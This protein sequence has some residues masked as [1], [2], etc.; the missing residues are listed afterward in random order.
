MEDV[1]AQFQVWGQYFNQ[2][3]TNLKK[4]P[5]QSDQSWKKFCRWFKSNVHLMCFARLEYLWVNL[6]PR[7]ASLL[8]DQNKRRNYAS[9]E[10]TIGVILSTLLAM[11]IVFVGPAQAS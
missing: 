8:F 5:D 7:L 6:N 9:N 2:F 4:D 11:L 3:L 1:I 10:N